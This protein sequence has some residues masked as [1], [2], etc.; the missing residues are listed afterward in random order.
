MADGAERADD[1]PRS[2][3]DA[4]RESPTEEVYGI[5][6]LA[7]ELGTTTRAI[8]FYE[9][10]G[11]LDPK[12]VGTTRVYGRRERARL[13]LILRGKKLGLTLREMKQY[14]DMYGERGEGRVKQLEMVVERTGEMIA[15]L[16]DKKAHI[17]QTLAE[18]RLIRRES[19]RK[20]RGRKG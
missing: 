12:R 11:L 6:E 18:L 20:L 10:K 13:Q 15:E 2:F 3:V 4:H 19:Q 1:S 14:L 8:R 7:R 5:G 16:E 17:E 9:T